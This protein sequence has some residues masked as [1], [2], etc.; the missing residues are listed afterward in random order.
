[1]IRSRV[2]ALGRLQST[3]PAPPHQVRRIMAEPP[4]Q[5]EMQPHVERLA[6]N[7]ARAHNLV[8]IYRLLT[9]SQP[10]R[11]SVA[12]SDVLRS[13]VV[14]IHASL[15]DFLRSLA[16]S[17]LPVAKPDVVASIPLKGMGRGGRPEKFSLG[18]LHQHRG[19]TVDEV[20]EQSI[21]AYLERSNYSSTSEIAA[22]LQ[23]LEI[24]V[25]PCK[26]FFPEL[27]KMM[28]RRHQIVHRADCTSELGRGRHR[29]RSI[30]VI[31]VEKW[32][33]AVNQ[34]HGVVLDQLQLR[35]G[36]NV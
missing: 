36:R 2:P 18:D 6:W 10:G 29:G 12:H 15:E 16:R 21:E 35:K 33:N 9:G 1:M 5:P 13:A 7:L 23:S 14:L 34:L 32:I 25:G 20:I 11:R 4:A 17:Y 31:T 3:W 24:D 28:E 30:S 8:S 19:K 27:D 26:P 22:L